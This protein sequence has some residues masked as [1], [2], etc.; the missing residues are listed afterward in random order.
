MKTLPTLRDKKRYIAFE[1][2]SERAINRNELY[3]E[4]SGSTGSLFGDAGCSEIDFKLLS[5]DGRCGIMRCAHG[6]TQETRAALACVNKING[7]RVSILVLGIS[8]TVRGA[9][10]KFIQPFI[11]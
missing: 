7:M 1:V 6:R 10:E 9:M 2:T 3:K 8:G 5:F 11:H 4:I